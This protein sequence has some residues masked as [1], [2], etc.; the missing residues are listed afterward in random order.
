MVPK[1]EKI[2]SFNRG[3]NFEKELVDYEKN[4]FEPNEDDYENDDNDE[5]I[6]IY[7]EES[8]NKN[9]LYAYQR[10]K[11]PNEEENYIYLAENGDLHYVDIEGNTFKCREENGDLIL[12]E[13]V[14]DNSE[15]LNKINKKC[16]KNIKNESKKLSKQISKEEDEHEKPDLSLKEDKCNYLANENGNFIEIEKTEVVFEEFVFSRNEEEYE[17]QNKKCKN[18]TQVDKKLQRI[19]KLRDKVIIN[20]LNKKNSN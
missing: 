10:V 6:E 15:Y 7:E 11:Y 20:E 19:H 3:E 2:F 1:F 18:Y 8:P 14:V 4:Q 5:E 9:K 16:D 13:R 12:E 17:F